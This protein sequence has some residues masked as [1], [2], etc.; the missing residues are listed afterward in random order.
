MPKT[1]RVFASGVRG[2]P[3]GQQ[4]DDLDIAERAG[5]PH[6]G[7]EQRLRDGVSRVDPYA[8]PRTNQL[9]GL[10]GGCKPLIILG[11]PSSP[12]TAHDVH[13]TKHQLQVGLTLQLYYRRG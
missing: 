7:F 13:L 9:H 12:G 2:V 8:V 3:E 10:V 5:A 1:G 6:Q 11:L 4:V